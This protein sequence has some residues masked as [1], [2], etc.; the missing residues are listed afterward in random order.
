MLSHGIGSLSATTQVKVF[1]PDMTVNALGQGFHAPETNI[2]IFVNG[3]NITDV[4]GSWAVAGK[5]IDC[6][7][8]WEN[9]NVSCGN[10]PDESFREA[11]EA[12]RKCGVW[13][14]GLIHSRGVNR[15]MPVEFYEN[16]ALEGVSS[17]MKSGE[18][19]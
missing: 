19:L 16:K 5:R 9:P 2:R 14:V 8:T 1:S 11:E 3:E 4:P 15:V 6:F 10:F 18:I 13:V 12:T 7:G 17:L